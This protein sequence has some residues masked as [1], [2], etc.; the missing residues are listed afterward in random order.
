MSKNSQVLWVRR[1]P[2]S[3]DTV[4]FLDSRK[5]QCSLGMRSDFYVLTRPARPA[6]SSPSAG[7]RT[8][9]PVR[10]APQRLI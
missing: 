3:N 1:S 9:S 4:L 8:F 5:V 2:A 7:S 6:I 10:W